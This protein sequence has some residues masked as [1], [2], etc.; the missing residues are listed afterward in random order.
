MAQCYSDITE[1]AMDHMFLHAPEVIARVRSHG[2]VT[3]VFLDELGIV[4]LPEGSHI[5]RDALVT[6][7][8]HAHVMSHTDSRAKFVDYLQMR[9]DRNNPA[10]QLQLKEAEKAAKTLA[11]ETAAR[12]KAEVAAREKAERESQKAAEKER[13]QRLSPAQKKAEIAQRK[14]EVAQ[15][16]A[17]LLLQNDVEVP[18]PVIAE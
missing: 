14:V 13:R 1:D 17:A 5:N 2:A 16:K 18:V 11:R 9:A 3:D 8:Q 10:L 4:K 15:R 7:R 6:W 12:E